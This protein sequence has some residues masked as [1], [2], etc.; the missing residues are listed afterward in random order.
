MIL[1]KGFPEVEVI[2]TCKYP[3]TYRTGRKQGDY[4]IEETV[5]DSGGISA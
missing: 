4:I 3:G 5:T 2:Q 1:F